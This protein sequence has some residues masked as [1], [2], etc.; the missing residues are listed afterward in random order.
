MVPLSCWAGGDPAFGADVEQMH[1]R[2]GISNWGREGVKEQP[3]TA[4]GS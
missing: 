4:Q 3:Q 2:A 1:P